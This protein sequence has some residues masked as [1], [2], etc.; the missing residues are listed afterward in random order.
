LVGANEVGAALG[1]FVGP[2]V[3]IQLGAALGL[4]VLGAPDGMPVGAREGAIDGALDGRVVGAAVGAA[5][6]HSSTKFDSPANK[7][8]DEY[9]LEPDGSLPQLSVKL[10]VG[11]AN[12]NVT[13]ADLSCSLN[14]LGSVGLS[15]ALGQ[16]APG[17]TPDG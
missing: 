2:A 7:K 15:W 3:G 8:P 4:P 17:H 11:L 13:A 16:V 12:S 9:I 1:T 10:L 6:G 5:V 14:A